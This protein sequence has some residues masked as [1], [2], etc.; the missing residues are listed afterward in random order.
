MSARDLVKNGLVV[1]LDIGSTKVSCFIA[2]PD[3]A[4]G[5]RVV[6]IGHQAASGLRNG[7]VV[8]LDAAEESIRTAVDAAE[9]M[10][11]ETVRSVIVNLSGG[12]PWSRLISVEVD[13]AGHPVGERDLARAQSQARSACAAE[14]GELIH[15]IPAGYTV[16]GA[17]GYA[18]P[19]GMYGER[20]GVRTN[21]I[22]ANA[23][24]LRNLRL[25][26]ERSHLDVAQVVL[27]PYAAGLATVV[28][29]ESDLGVTVVDMGGGCTSIGVFFEGSLVYGDVIP[30][31]GGHVTQ[32]IA[33]GLS[34][35]LGHAERLKTLY[36]SAIAGPSDDH[37]MLVVPEVG[38]DSGQATRDVPRSML[39]GII[40]PRI[41]ETLELVRARLRESGA[42][43]V[44]GRRVVLTGGA[45][46]LTG[47]RE[48]TAQVL[49]KQVRVGRPLRL[50]GLADAVAG[51]AFAVSAGLIAYAT[52]GME[53]IALGRLADAGAGGGRLS[54]IGRWFK[55]N[56]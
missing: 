4:G 37:E 29:D 42:E 22:T 10:A 47:V 11:G 1:A 7:A 32:D 18:S 21:I 2:R 43:N 38:D 36:G 55:E 20:L 45:S 40:Q 3:G 48:L 27:S 24:P 6:G 12:Y 50:Q 31:G 52:R 17:R 9:R 5:A 19:L 54:R 26:V 25:L 41:E 15:A 35:P 14:D 34:T 13:I 53:E 23:G 33:R 28:E 39:I 30:V 44:A 49:D 16:D 51:P 46:Q 8:D 56:F